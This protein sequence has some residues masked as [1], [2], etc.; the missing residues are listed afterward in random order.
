MKKAQTHEIEIR[1]PI[2][3]TFG[4]GVHEPADRLAARL[5]RLA[6]AER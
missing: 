1:V 5:R 6:W 2:E 4:D 3:A